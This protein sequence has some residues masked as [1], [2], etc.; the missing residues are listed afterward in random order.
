MTAEIAVMNRNAVALAADSAVTIQ[1]P[2]GPKIYHTN[3]VFALSKYEPIGVMV[4]GSADFMGLP[5]ETIIKQY[6]AQLGRRSFSNLQDYGDSILRY[7]EQSR[8]L[9][10]ASLQEKYLHQF[11]HA[12]MHRFKVRLRAALREKAKLGNPIT[13]T[14]IRS[15]AREL[16]DAQVARI[17]KNKR[18]PR[19]SRVSPSVLVSRYG[20]ALRTGIEAEL[21]DFP[22]FVS[23]GRLERTIALAITRDNQW[24]Q[25]S[26][27]VVAGFGRTQTMPSMRS[28]VLDGI[29]A[30]RLRAAFVEGKGSDVTDD[31][32]AVVTAF[33]QSEM[34]SLFMNGIDPEFREYMFG[35]VEK[36]FI[37]G[38]PRAVKKLLETHL[39]GPAL[40]KLT[41][42]L[43]DIG[44][45]LDAELKLGTHEYSRVLHW[46]PIIE[47]V[48]HL[49]KEELAAMAEALV[50]LT[51]F[52]RH[53]T[54]QAETVGGPID[55]VVISR[56]DGLIWIKRKHY[57]KTELNQHFLANYYNDC[58][59]A[60]SPY[61]K[62]TRF[63]P[64]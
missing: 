63:L 18:L 1:L 15:A 51:S 22:R 20:R 10:K 24:N 6:R 41:R 54:R 62:A 37:D 28:Y 44:K 35:F 4:F 57:F 17:Q 12:W 33:A 45:K 56:G 29:V 7:I 3:K 27:I 42:G 26:G 43:R 50:N 31:N 2:E 11:A 64:S 36:S 49:P 9:R 46:S 40:A 8:D 25:E 47:I 61:E 21:Q 5:W 14:S 59:E 16:F 38:Y 55:V 23:V 53:V 19:L 60:Q 58:R 30:D 48:R 52:K 34:A 13:T 32:G 39:K